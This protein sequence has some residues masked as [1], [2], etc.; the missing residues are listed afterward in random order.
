M[1]ILS[2]IFPKIFEKESISVD[3]CNDF[4]S[5]IMLTD[6]EDAISKIKSSHHSAFVKEALISLSE[7]GFVLLKK[8]NSFAAC[9]SVIL[10]FEDYCRS[11][12]E[13][14]NFRDENG[15][16]DRLCN[17]QIQYP[18]A[19]DLALNP[20]VLSILEAAMNSPVDV[21][22]SLFFERGSE[23]DIHRDSPAFYTIPLNRY[24]GVWNAL[25]DIHPEAGALVYYAGGHKIAPDIEY[26]GSGKMNEYFDEIE[27]AC[28]AAGL[29]KEYLIAEKG[30]TLIWH[31][32][33]PHGGSTILDKKR[34]RRSI[35]IHYKGYGLPIFGGPEFFG[36]KELPDSMQDNFGY[37]TNRSR[38]ILDHGSIVFQRNRKEGNFDQVE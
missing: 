1:N 36:L 30:D 24:F 17:L 9:N 32:Q 33:L 25:E 20:N 18:A 2:K 10:A 11:N 7:K 15:L 6:G 31:P 37:L 38:R 23:Q 27:Q 5:H 35:V 13:H 14:L 19:A 12:G 34:S 21:V 8:N 3:S 16:H 4:H 26:L 28:I 29:K 22:G